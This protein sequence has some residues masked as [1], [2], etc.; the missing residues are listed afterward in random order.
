MS[1]PTPPYGQQRPDQ[2]GNPQVPQD[3]WP[4][5]TVTFGYAQPGGTRQLPYGAEF[6]ERNPRR[7]PSRTTIVIALAAVVTLLLGGTA[8][9][10]AWVWYGWGATQPEEALPATSAV[11]ARIDLSPGLGQ[12][13]ALDNLA[14]KFP[15]DGKSTRDFVEQ[16][17]RDLTKQLGLEPL[18]YDRDV[19]PWFADRIGF[20]AW[21]KDGASTDPCGLIAMASKDDRA[22]GAAP[23]KVRDRKGAEGFGFAFTNG[24]A[25]LVECGA[26][27]DSQGTADAAIAAI[28]RESLAQHQPF[29]DALAKLPSGQT[30]VGW[31]DLAAAERT[32]PSLIGITGRVGSLSTGSGKGQVI[33]GAKATGDGVELRYRW[34]G[35]SAP[36]NHRDVLG[37]L[38]ALP[39]NTTIGAAADL[40]VVRETLGDVERTLG[41]DEAPDLPAS[42]LRNGVDAILG[43]VVS[44]AVSDVGAADDNPA[45]RVVAKAASAAASADITELLDALGARPGQ[46]PPGVAI[47]SSGD[48]VT[49]TAGAYRAAD[50]HLSDRAIYRDAMAGASGTSTVA[51]FVDVARL[52]ASLH[53][54]AKQAA[55]IKPLKAVGLTTGYDGDTMVGLVRAIIR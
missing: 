45:V 5:D 11:F 36:Q 35:V 1:D 24:Y 2:Y 29:A 44:I 41:L 19:K 39:G 6:G 12:R 22:A 18:D 52:T 27:A 3:P 17:K 21:A 33:L 9:A 14:K 32:L 55:N 38:G 20:A 23:R 15:K 13:L 8:I 50:G 31:A 51:V 53:L 28:Q 40:Y 26:A 7:R 34:S 16:L 30:A 37:E 48:R 43:S 49:V 46:L 10:G 54:G 47:E 4:T 42:V 25:V